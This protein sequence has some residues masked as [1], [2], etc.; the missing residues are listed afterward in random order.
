MGIEELKL[1]PWDRLLKQPPTVWRAAEILWRK[2]KAM[3]LGYDSPRKL[4]PIL[5]KL[6]NEPRMPTRKQQ[7]QRFGQGNRKAAG[8]R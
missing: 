8:K 6:A 2:R 3:E 1:M 4:D 5:K 7:G